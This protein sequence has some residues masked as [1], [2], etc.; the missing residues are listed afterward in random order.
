LSA[1]FW[2]AT[3]ESAA[4]AAPA[5]RILRRTCEVIVSLVPLGEV[6]APVDA[7]RQVDAPQTLA[8]NMPRSPPSA[9]KEFTRT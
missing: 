4:T 2:Q 9:S 6:S 3:I 8:L 5:T 7:K 1:G